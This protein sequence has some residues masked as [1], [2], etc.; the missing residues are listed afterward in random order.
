[1]IVLVSAF[2][3][4]GPS[5]SRTDDGT[6]YIILISLLVVAFVVIIVALLCYY[7]RRIRS[8]TGFNTILENN[9]KTTTYTKIALK[10]Q[11]QMPQ[12]SYHLCRLLLRRLLFR[13]LTFCANQ[14]VT[15]D[16]CEIY[17]RMPDLHV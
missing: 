15:E 2:D 9:N 17:R 4:G 14:I 6:Y 13:Q 5:S 7:G 1:M 12:K 3:K 11:G 8:L 10:G 16:H